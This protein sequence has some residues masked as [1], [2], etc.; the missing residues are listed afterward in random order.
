[1]NGIYIIFLFYIITTLIEFIC[2]KIFQ[3]PITVNEDAQKRL[4]N[5]ITHSTE[6]SDKFKE[7]INDRL[8]LLEKMSYEDWLDY[9]NKNVTFEFND[10]SYYLF[11]YEK[12]NIDDNFILRASVQQELVNLN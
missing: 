7:V 9:N 5:N 1:M 11:I 8:Q 10:I 4:N 2:Y 6:L 12:A 3:K